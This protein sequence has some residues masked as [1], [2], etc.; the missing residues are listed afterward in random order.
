VCVCALGDACSDGALCTGGGWQR[1][2][3]WWLGPLSIAERVLPWVRRRMSSVTRVHCTGL[4]CA[5]VVGDGGR[6]V[7]PRAESWVP[8]AQVKQFS[9]RSGFAACHHLV[10][11]QFLVLGG[12]APDGTFLNDWWISS[13]G[14]EWAA[15]CRRRWLCPGFQAL[16]HGLRPINLCPPPPSPLQCPGTTS[17]TLVRFG[18]LART[19]RALSSTVCCWSWGAAMLRVAAPRMCGPTRKVGR[20]A[21]LLSCMQ[22][23]CGLWI[24]WPWWC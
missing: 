9:P 6:L 18:P 17:P 2:A 3:P 19:Q 11:D 15:G 8:V 7:R 13:D 12:I 20:H 23:P 21:C 5:C 24:G 10:P 4:Y 14:G 1:S 16:E 22:S